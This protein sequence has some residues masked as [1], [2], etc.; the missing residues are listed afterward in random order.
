MKWFSAAASWQQPCNYGGQTQQ[1]AA[2]ILQLSTF[3]SPAHSSSFFPSQISK[4]NVSCACVSKHE[5]CAK[6]KICKIWP[7]LVGFFFILPRITRQTERSDLIITVK[8]EM[9]IRIFIKPA[10]QAP[11]EGDNIF[12]D[13][14][15]PLIL[16]IS[17]ILHLWSMTGNP[18]SI[19]VSIPHPWAWRQL[20]IFLTE[21]KYNLCNLI[22]KFIPDSG[23]VQVPHYPMELECTEMHN[24]LMVF[25]YLSST[26][27]DCNRFSD[28]PC[29]QTF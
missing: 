24:Y 29:I 13:F 4:Q 17:K 3:V 26:I 20:F 11:E 15:Y 8:W 25:S 10:R 22:I 5:K 16:K 19:P 28:F 21:D 2:A 23:S 1:P 12:W 6:W 27:C 14:S 9:Y 18:I 7:L